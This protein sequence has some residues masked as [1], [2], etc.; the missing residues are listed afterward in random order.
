M[1]LPTPINA[2]TTWT[3]TADSHRD[4]ACI[5]REWELVNIDI[6]GKEMHFL[7]G[8]VVSDY[9]GRWESGDYVFTSVIDCFYIDTGLVQ[10]KNSLYCLQGDGEEVFATIEEAAKMRAIGQSLHTIRAI[11][12]DVGE[13][14][15]S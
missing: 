5:V 3:E 10:T 7:Y 1:K 4:T 12:R 8:T 2:L 14:D 11:E 13:I 6:D 15:L 9:K